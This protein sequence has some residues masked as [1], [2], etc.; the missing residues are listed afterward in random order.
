M[1]FHTRAASL[2]ALVQRHSV[3]HCVP[4]SGRVLCAACAPSRFRQRLARVGK[5][6]ARFLVLLIVVFTG[7]DSCNSGILSS[8]CRNIVVRLLLSVRAVASRAPRVVDLFHHEQQCL[9]SNLRCVSI[10]RCRFHTALELRT[11]VRAAVGCAVVF[12]ANVLRARCKASARKLAS[13]QHAHRRAAFRI[14][15]LVSG[16]AGLSRGFERSMASRYRHRSIAN[17]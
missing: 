10:C 12:C 17:P 2:S 13:I 16:A 6:T 1:A 15:R 7:V 11:V 3:H 8:A 9:P 14:L 5:R 4:V